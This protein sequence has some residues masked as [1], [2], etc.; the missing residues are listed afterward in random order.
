M[1][2]G[3]DTPG[4]ALP[5]TAADDVGAAHARCWDALLAAD[6]AALDT[7]LAGGLTF[8]SPY[9]TDETKAAFLGNLRSG[10]LGYDSNM[11]AE[12]LTWLHGQVGIVTGRAVIQ[13]RWDGNLRAEG[14]YCTAVYGW[15][16]PHWRMRAWQKKLRADAKG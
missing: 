3:G 12:P 15:A 14:L 10:R 11:D 9:G 16:A 13:F 7:L 4:A 8:H 2:S 6:A 1:A 5:P